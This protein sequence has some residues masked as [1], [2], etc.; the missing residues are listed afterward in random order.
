[1]LNIIPKAI[2]PYVDDPHIVPSFKQPEGEALEFI[3]KAMDIFHGYQQ[4]YQHEGKSG[5]VQRCVLSHP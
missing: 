4:A 3:R 5:D 1:M 2:A